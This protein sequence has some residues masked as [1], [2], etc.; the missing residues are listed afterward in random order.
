MPAIEIPKQ[1]AE[2]TDFNKIPGIPFGIN[3]PFE[4]ALKA[5]NGEEN[6]YRWGNG[7]SGTPK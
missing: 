7:A 5:I 4:R 2:K 6:Y 1:R 3:Y